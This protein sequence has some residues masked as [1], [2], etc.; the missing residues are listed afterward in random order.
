MGAELLLTRL[1]VA[2]AAILIIA[3]AAAALLSPNTIKRLAGVTIA[4]LGSV[5]ALAALG[6]PEFALTS[7]V[8]VLFA[9]LTVG[10]AIA[11]RLQESYGSIEAPEIDAADEQS[12][13]RD[14][15]L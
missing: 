4:G 14:T 7:G 6:A 3:G 10:V 11:V 13:P 12:E 1:L 9:Q 2:G 15:P 8:A 5:A